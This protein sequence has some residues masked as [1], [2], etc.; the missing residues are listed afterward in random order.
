MV[1]VGYSLWN[2][3]QRHN[4]DGLLQDAIDIS[5]SAYE[6]FAGELDDSDRDNFTIVANLKN[7]LC[8]YLAEQE[9]NGIPVPPEARKLALAFTIDGF[10]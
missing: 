2:Q 7:S 10:L 6:R 1:Y 3:Y 9:A 8:Y 4:D 5:Q